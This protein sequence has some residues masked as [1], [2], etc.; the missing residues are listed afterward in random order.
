MSATECLRR[1]H[2]LIVNRLRNI[3]YEYSKY[4]YASNHIPVNEVKHILIVIES[5]ISMYHHYK[6]ECSYF[7]RV[8]G[9]ELEKEA[10]ALKIE[11]EFGRRIARMLNSNLENWL[12][13][14]GSSEPIARM[15]KAYADY[16]TVHMEREERFFD[17]YDTKVPESEQSKVR[18]E[19][20]NIRVERMPEH[21]MDSMV[22]MLNML[23][24]NLTKYLQNK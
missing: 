14:R 5:F 11:H 15:L 8:N 13:T 24:N 9:T 7:P 17:A 12:S 3:A 20:N 22:E 6:E 2:K 1:D 10:D 21:V 16:L 18:E 19:F 23:E 4:I